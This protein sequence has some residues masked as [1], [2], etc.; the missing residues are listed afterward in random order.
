MSPTNFTLVVSFF[1]LLGQH[2][3]RVV[4]TLYALQLHADPFTVGVLAAVSAVPPMA[5][6]WHVGRF[7]DRFGSR[8]LLAMSGLSGAVGMLVPYV[9][10]GLAALFVASAMCGLL[11][12]FL[13]A[14]VQNLMGLLSRPEDRVKN[15]S[16]L[17]LVVS[18][19]GFAGP[20][21]AGFSIDHAG[22]GVACL[23]TVLLPLIAAALLVIWGDCLPSGTRPAKPTGSVRVLLSE[24]GLWRVLT[25]SSLVVMGIE[26][27]QVF[28]PI[29]GKDIG[30]SASAIGIILA[31]Y[32]VAAFVIR[33]FLSALVKRFAAERVL[34]YSFLIGATGF[35]LVPFC[36]GILMLSLVAFIFGIG[37]GC[38]QPVTLMMTFSN[39]TEGRSGEALGVRVTVNNLARV[40]GQVLF[41][42]IASVLGVFAVFW[43]NALLFAS[44]WIASRPGG[45]RRHQKG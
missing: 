12:A 25:T 33:L 14:P 8:W 3:G 17:T 45:D 34:A 23:I 28:L 27:Y 15:F 36:K 38:G 24:S 42:S 6:S 18:F 13:V 5:F 16:N 41:G 22:P 10:P 40:T 30:L 26:L 19:A 29:Y 31:T 1:L 35:L 43:I 37:T 11:S 32:A 20:L 21:L 2:A 44:G 7:T 9:A 4:I 39:S